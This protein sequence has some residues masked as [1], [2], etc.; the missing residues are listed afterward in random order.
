MAT[1]ATLLEDKHLI[2]LNLPHRDNR[3]DRTIKIEE[4]VADV[5]AVNLNVENARYTFKSIFYKKE[6]RG[7]YQIN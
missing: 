6:E 5:R 2:S 4:C 3:R 7:Q 1:Q